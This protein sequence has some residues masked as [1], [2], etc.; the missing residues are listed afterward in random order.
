MSEMG[1]IDIGE[2]KRQIDLAGRMKG[3]EKLVHMRRLLAVIKKI[4]QGY[5]FDYTVPY[6]HLTEIRELIPTVEGS[7]N[8]LEA[9]KRK[10]NGGS[11]GSH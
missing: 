1:L 7:L 4:E 9:A 6:G 2:L 10:K 8:R 3:E 11:N 5:M